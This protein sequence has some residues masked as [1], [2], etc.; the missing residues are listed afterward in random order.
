MK[1]LA[2]I[3]FIKVFAMF[4]VT[5]G[6]CAQALS[7]QVFP[8]R[9]IPNDLFISIHMPL[10]MIA[11]GFVLNFDKIRETPTYGYVKN[12]FQRLII[13][14]LVWLGI[15]CIITLQKPTF[16]TYWYLSALFFSLVTL[17]VFASFIKNNA[18]LAI[19]CILFILINPFSIVSHTNFMFPFLMYGFLLKNIINK[20]NLY[21]LLPFGLGFIFLYI[22]YWSIEH[23]VYLAPLD[24]MNL[25]TNVLYSF[26]LR[27]TIGIL[28]STSLFLLAKRYDNSNVIKKISKYGRYTLIFYTMTTVI[29]GITRRIFLF[30]NISI[31][32]PLLLDLTSIIFALLQMYIIYVFAK[33]VEGRKTLSKLLLGN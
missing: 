21:Y 6:H 7:C 2:Y 15:F 18:L 17:K 9:Y 26:I 23:T 24:V 25:N 14:L 5:I 30:A 13:P 22:F 16:H 3:D 20:M 10:F 8:A 27:L 33:N 1:R 29:N 28:G 12:K 4:I 31:T 19:V 32:S 11:S